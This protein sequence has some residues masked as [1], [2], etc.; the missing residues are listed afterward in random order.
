MLYFSN[1]NILQYVAHTQYQYMYTVIQC[2]PYLVSA[3][4]IPRILSLAQ[5]YQ[6]MGI[7]CNVSVVLHILR[8]GIFFNIP[9]TR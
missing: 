4:V 2:I 6:S 9:G 5:E 3:G 1:H 7:R 8:D